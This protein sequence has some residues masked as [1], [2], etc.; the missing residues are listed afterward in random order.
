MRP[1]V[2]HGEPGGDLFWA[3]GAPD[4][5][6]APFVRSYQDFAERTD[7]PLT[8]LEVPSGELVVI[9]DFGDGWTVGQGETAPTRMGSFAGGLHD[10][11]AIAGHDGRARCM[12]LN[13]TPLGARALLGVPPGELAHRCVALEDLLGADARRLADALEGAGDWRARFDRLDA[14]LARR[15][16]T[17]DPLRADVAFALGALRAAGGAV[18]VEA[19]ADEL[20]CSRRHLSVRFRE[21]VGLSP[22]AYARVLRFDRAA[23]MLRDGAGL[24]DAAHACGYADQPHFTRDFRALTGTTPTRYL[25]ARIGIEGVAA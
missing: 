17:V 16:A 11:P 3:I 22:K 24:A 7:G 6:L 8:R 4:P 23:R 1:H 20:G 18:R 25:D 15:A 12:Q 2:V 14:L 19:L 21:Q 13:L 5:R 10:G 9:V